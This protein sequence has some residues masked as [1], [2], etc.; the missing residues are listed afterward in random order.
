MNFR[1]WLHLEQ[2]YEELQQWL[3]QTGTDINSLVQQLSQKPPDFKGGNA[4]FWYIPNSPFG[5][6]WVR[7]RQPGSLAQQEDPFADMN[8]GQPIANLGQG[9][10]ILRVQ[11]GSPAGPVHGVHKLPADQQEKELG[12]YRKKML[13]SAAMPQEAYDQLLQQ[14]VTIN[15]RGYQVDPSKPGNLLIDPGKGFGLVDVNPSE[16]GRPND[17]GH[18]I[19]MLMGGNF[20]FNKISDPE[21]QQAAQTIIQKVETAAKKVG[22]PFDKESSSTDYSYELAGLK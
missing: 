9:V 6:R 1:E 18:V 12:V 17:A 14:I 15:Q 8:V 4:D 5:L 13:D 10:Q 3:Q 21:T 11:A 16:S 20:H 7:G 19:V 22:M 2:N